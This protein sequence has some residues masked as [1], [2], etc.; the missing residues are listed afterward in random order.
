MRPIK[1]RYWAAARDAAGV[2]E[3]WV[4]AVT[5][6][7]LIATA[8]ARRGPG[9]AAVLAIS[10]FLVDDQPVGRRAPAAVA[11]AAATVVEVLP[12]FAGG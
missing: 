5:L 8:A 3:E 4:E 2:T 1:V 7:D 10:S 6:A 12:P 9:L 11:L